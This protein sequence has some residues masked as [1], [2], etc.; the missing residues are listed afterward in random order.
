MPKEILVEDYLIIKGY[1]LIDVRSPGEFIAGHV[2]GA[3]NIPLF[4]D[5]ERTRLGIMYK[6]EGKNKAVL[7]GFEFVGPKLG[8]LVQQYSKY[9][10]DNKL[11]LY[12]WRGGQ[13]SASVAWLLDKA[14]FEIS[15]IH[16]GYK[17]YRRFIN[18]YFKNQSF[19]F[20]VLGGKTGS[21]K[22]KILEELKRNNEQVL[23]LEEL[24]HHKGSAFGWIGE[25]E[26]EPNEQFENNLFT[27]LFQ[28]NLKRIIW[29][30]NESR[31]IGKNYIPDN[32]WIKI[33]SSILVQI[34]IDHQDRIRH[35]MD[36]YG[37]SDKQS[38]ILS[39][40]KIAKRL[41][42]ENAQKAID[43]IHEN[44]F[45]E[46]AQIAL[47][48]YDKCYDFNFKENRSPEIISL[49]MHGKSIQ[50]IA[51]E[52]VEFSSQHFKLDHGRIA[53]DSI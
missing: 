53:I 42:Y 49:S 8:D 30:E 45:E 48:Y 40:S 1:N 27:S 29:V 47:S 21:A 19:R 3:M 17:A 20:V 24:A 34:E 38:L 18:G 10:I 16:K 50:Q 26:Q 33:K 7:L 25:G 14:G 35:L 4:T 51:S 46:A 36:S 23:N 11:F 22:T 28:M 15:L 2:P 12:C 32:L 13:R 9:I 31:K 5:E 44:Q 39:F 43:H 6:M 37:I 41:G 52:L